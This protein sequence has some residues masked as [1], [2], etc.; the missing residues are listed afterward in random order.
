MARLRLRLI[1]GL[2]LLGT[3]FLLSPSKDYPLELESYGVKRRS[4]GGK[5][6][7]NIVTVSSVTSE[8][9]YAQIEQWTIHIHE[10]GEVYKISPVTLAAILF[11]E[12]LHRKP[13]DVQTIGPAQ[14]GLDELEIQNLP[15][16]RRLLEDPEI[17]IW[18]L[19]RKLNRLRRETGSLDRAIILHNGFNDFLFSVRKRE[20][21]SRL[22]MILEMSRIRPLTI[23]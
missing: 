3:F 17:S 21:D 22:R 9:S 14:L 19:A 2:L 11:E 23:T 10:A 15:R 12:A 1:V 6:V 16:D 18:I 7:S 20:Q 13:I 8:A 4:Q 5:L